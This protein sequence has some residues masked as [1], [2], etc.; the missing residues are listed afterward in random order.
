MNN[1]KT[2]DGVSSRRSLH[3]LAMVNTGIWA[4]AMIPL[5]FVINDYSGAKGMYPILGGGTAVSIALIS[6]IKRAG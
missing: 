5:V 3:T 2:E 6:A 4:L 1:Q